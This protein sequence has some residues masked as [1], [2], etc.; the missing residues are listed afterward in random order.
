MPLKQVNVA[1]V[2]PLPTSTNAADNRQ[3]LPSFIDVHQFLVRD[4]NMTSP[5]LEQRQQHQSN[6]NPTFYSSSTTSWQQQQ[7]KFQDLSQNGNHQVYPSPEEKS[8]PT[9]AGSSFLLNSPPP[10]MSASSSR[11]SNASSFNNS[12]MSNYHP[13]NV[14]SGY[15]IDQDAM[16]S[17]L[18]T[19]P[20]SS[21]AFDHHHQQNTPSS[22]G[23]HHQ[24]HNILNDRHGNSTQFYH[25]LPRHASL[26][27]SYGNNNASAYQSSSYGRVGYPQSSN[28]V[29][30]TPSSSAS[31]SYYGQ[32][33]Q[34]VVGPL[35]I[36]TRQPSSNSGG[37]ASSLASSLASAH[38]MDTS[39]FFSSPLS[40]SMYMSPNNAASMSLKK[41]KSQGAIRTGSSSN[42]KS[43]SSPYHLSNNPEEQPREQRLKFPGDMYTPKWVRF[44][45]AAKE[46][47]CDLCDG[48]GKWLQL[49]NS[50]FWYV[51]YLPSF[52]IIFSLLII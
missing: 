7:P 35:R 10:V 6:V 14:P 3:Q 52:F 49:K 47:L 25:P 26:S 12:S 22:Y 20:G 19:K 48:P 45:G 24:N 17:L 50:A 21:A 9:P 1:Q 42:G 51:L 18:F 44:Q 32:Q 38:S 4:M 29:Y 13:L 2:S 40:E 31:S 27:S 34:D 33:Q 37:M 39:S 43:S 23:S 36:N 30:Q 46:G 28:T 11:T 15:P 16:V 8:P 5:P 41:R